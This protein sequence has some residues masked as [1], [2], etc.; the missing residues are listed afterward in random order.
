MNLRNQRELEV[1]REKL[2]M[3]EEEQVAARNRP[4]PNEHVRE[5]TLR[6]LKKLINQLKEEII[7]YESH[8]TDRAKNA[9]GS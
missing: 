5:L 9:L 7:R 6:S 4:F 2:R 8:M 3:L 1:T